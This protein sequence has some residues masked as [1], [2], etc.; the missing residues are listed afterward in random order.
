MMAAIQQILGCELLFSP[1]NPKLL[2]FGDAR[3]YDAGFF[4]FGRKAASG[5]L[6]APAQV[7]V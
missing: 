6:M 2:G 1:A 4:C 5:R 3:P 7:R